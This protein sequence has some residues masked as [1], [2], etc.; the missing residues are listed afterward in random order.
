MEFWAGDD[1]S[2][3]AYIDKHGNQKSSWDALTKM[4]GGVRSEAS[5][6]SRW[7]RLVKG[8]VKGQT[9]RPCRPHRQ[10]LP[11]RQVRRFDFNSILI[12]F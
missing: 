11:R 8:K 5:L 7:S 12:R 9:V 6:R 1:R 3:L 10:A 2:L 4:F